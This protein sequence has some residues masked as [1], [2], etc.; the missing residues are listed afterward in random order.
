M[1]L[2][3]LDAEQG[4]QHVKWLCAFLPE[5]FSRRAGEHDA[6]LTLLLVNRLIFKCE[7][8]ATQ[9]KLKSNDFL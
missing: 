2:R 3:K 1:E 7:L 8:L 4:V 5:E 6:I 9:V